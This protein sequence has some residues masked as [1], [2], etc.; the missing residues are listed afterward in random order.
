MT[1]DTSGL[2]MTDSND[3]PAFP[4]TIDYKDGSKIFFPGMTLCDYFAAKA[5]AAIIAKTPFQEFPQ[6]YSP[7]KKTALGAYDYAEAML[8]TRKCQPNK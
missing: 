7:Y 2:V 4:S 3:G 6:D 8:E 1:T 5:M